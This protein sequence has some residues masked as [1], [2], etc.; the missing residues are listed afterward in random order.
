MRCVSYT[1]TTSCNNGGDIPRKT[2]EEQNA[3]ISQYAKEHNLRVVKKYTDRANDPA[4]ITGFEAMRMDG[5]SRGFDYVIIDSIWQCGEDIYQ[6]VRVLQNSFY[7]AG[8]HFAIV[9][10]TFN[11]LVKTPEEV[12]EYLESQRTLYHS[13][14][15]MVR[16]KKHPNTIH[17]NAYGY[18]YIEEENTLV[19]DEKSAAVI[20]R[21]FDDLQKGMKPREIADYLNSIK[22]E[23]PQD[24]LCRVRGWKLRGTN[25]G[26]SEGIVYKIAITPKYAGRW[27]RIIYGKDVTKDC[28]PIIE[29]EVFDNVQLILDQRRHHKKEVVRTAN[30]FHKI[31]FDADTGARVLK[32]KSKEPGK[33]VM[34][35]K[36]P[37]PKEADYPNTSMDYEEALSIVKQT[38]QKEHNA[39]LKAKEYV[40]SEAGIAYRE[41]IL[42][43]L[44]ECVPGFLDRISN[45]ET[46][47]IESYLCYVNGEIGET[48]YK[49]ILD[50][51]DR[52]FSDINV[53]LQ[54]AI[55]QIRDVLKAYSNDNPW[56]KLF[57]SYDAD[58]D[59]SRNYLHTFVSAVWFHQ[60]QSVEL[61]IRESQWRDMLYVN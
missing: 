40:L 53:E 46:N 41:K 1:R 47:R 18:R 43:K 52:M 20:K 57:V 32:Y 13:Y 56:I 22:A 51:C 4:A 60:F 27:E 21:I 3:D 15:V 19:I 14:K 58:H 6:A 55:Q 28:R 5:L 11:S 44:R 24:Y 8:I 25:R 34:R 9:E 42:R 17:L 35:F 29:P 38:L 54:N 45:N 59:L 23:N 2:I 50:N 31:A 61:A 33:H 36:Y 37:K 48:E 10:D 7:P 39:A 16:E 49:N 12:N 26:W 30:P